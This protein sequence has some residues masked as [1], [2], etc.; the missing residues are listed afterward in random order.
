MVMTPQEMHEAFTAYVERGEREGFDVLC[1][2]LRS[3]E[4]MIEMDDEGYVIKAPPKED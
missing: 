3:G 1:E 4:L 2:Q